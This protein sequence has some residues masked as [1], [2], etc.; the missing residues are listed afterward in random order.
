M[1]KNGRPAAAVAPM[2]R[3]GVCDSRGAPFVAGL[4][5]DGA[6][7]PRRADREPGDAGPVEV[8]AWRQ[9]LTGLTC[10]FTFLLRSFLHSCRSAV[11]TRNSGPSEPNASSICGS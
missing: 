8:F 7:V 6:V 2:P 1:P 3:C 4:R 11:L 10:F 9:G 5:Y